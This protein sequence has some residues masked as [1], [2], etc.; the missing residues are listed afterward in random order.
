MA[1][2]KCTG[3][4]HHTCGRLKQY[5]VGWGH[6]SV[7]KLLGPVIQ[8]Q[9]QMEA[10]PGRAGETAQGLRA[11]AVPAE[12]PS[13]A[14]GTRVVAHSCLYNSSHRESD[15]LFRLLR[16]PHFLACTLKYTCKKNKKIFKTNAGYGE[17]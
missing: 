16:A 7:R 4:L 13:S 8:S 14:P 12:N 9:H 6:G 17:W 11:P 2:V 1:A 5:C 15:S 10:G 3:G